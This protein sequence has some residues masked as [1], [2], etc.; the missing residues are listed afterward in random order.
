MILSNKTLDTISILASAFS[1]ISNN[2]EAFQAN[3]KNLKDTKKQADNSLKE[4]AEKRKAIKETIELLGV[5]LITLNSDREALNSD[6]KS[7]TRA[8]Q[9]LVTDMVVLKEE[10][11]ISNKLSEETILLSDI[12]VEERN[13]FDKKYKS[14][15]KKLD[16]READIASKE[17][18]I[19]EVMSVIHKGKGN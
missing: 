16:N 5:D 6:L 17:T 10:Q 19:N 9:K 7:F 15:Q 3:L 14:M 18:H 4:L 2:S 13:N 12:L 11:K 1:D 8:N